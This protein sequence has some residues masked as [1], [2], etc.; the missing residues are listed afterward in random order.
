M[1]GCKESN[2]DTVAQ[3]LTA[4]ERKGGRGGGG[5][6]RMISDVTEGEV[7]LGSSWC[8][9]FYLRSLVMRSSVVTSFST[10]AYQEVTSS[11]PL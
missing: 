6:L 5:R 11:V 4:K 10:E 1:K 3:I 8:W 2:P 9:P 7:F